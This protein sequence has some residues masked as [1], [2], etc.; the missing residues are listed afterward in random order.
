MS[1]SCFNLCDIDKITEG[2]IEFKK[3]QPTV[4]KKQ[5]MFSRIYLLRV[6]VE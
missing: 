4:K 3:K 5:A 1:R 2:E 6:I